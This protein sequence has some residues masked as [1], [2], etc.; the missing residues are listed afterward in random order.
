[1]H[2]KRIK[3]E[4][5]DVYQDMK[6]H[7]YWLI[8]VHHVLFYLYVHIIKQENYM[9]CYSRHDTIFA[10]TKKSHIYELNHSFGCSF[11][12]LANNHLT[13]TCFMLL[14]LE[15]KHIYIENIRICIRLS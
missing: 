1:M 13:L 14:S 9:F 4:D 15:N 6:H 10:Q 12:L 3:T 11:S 8:L 5:I 7:F 2:L